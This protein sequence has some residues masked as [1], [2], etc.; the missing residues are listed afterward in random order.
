GRPGAT[1][2]ALQGLGLIP[3]HAGSTAPFVW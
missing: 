2:D 1:G 3:A